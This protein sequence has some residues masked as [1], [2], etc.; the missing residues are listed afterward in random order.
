MFKVY[1]PSKAHNKDN[2]DQS[3]LEIRNNVTY[4]EHQVY[5]LEKALQVARASLNIS[6][7][8]SPVKQEPMQFFPSPLSEHTFHSQSDHFASP[9]SSYG[10]YEG[11]VDGSTCSFDSSSKYENLY[12]TITP[13]RGNF[14]DNNVYNTLSEIMESDTNTS[15]N[16]QPSQDL[17]L[18]SPTSTSAQDEQRKKDHTWSISVSRSTFIS[19]ALSMPC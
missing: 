14:T 5:E 15:P 11:M 4:L 7:V 13:Y 1:R 2:D 6:P 16:S 18:F 12:N 19:L 3:V 10:S 9:Q 17:V 8:N